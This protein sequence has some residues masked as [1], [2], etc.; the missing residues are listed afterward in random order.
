MGNEVVKNFSNFRNCSMLLDPNMHVYYVSS[1]SR[2]FQ[3]WISLEREETPINL[4][5]IPTSCYQN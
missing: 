4:F 3:G 5:K 2:G 1:L